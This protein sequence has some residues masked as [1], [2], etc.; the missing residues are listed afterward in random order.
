MEDSS[1]ETLE[2]LGACIA[3]RVLSVFHPSNQELSDVDGSGWQVH[4]RMEK[5]TAV[6]LADCPIVEVRTSGSIA[7]TLREGSDQGR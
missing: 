6:P 1:F 4:V 5:P 3:D 2:A 7:T